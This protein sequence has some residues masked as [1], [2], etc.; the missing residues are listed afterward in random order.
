[1]KARLTPLCMRKEQ[2]HNVV[3]V[4]RGR[5]LLTSEFGMAIE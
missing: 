4:C 1:M 5:D 3:G 2:K